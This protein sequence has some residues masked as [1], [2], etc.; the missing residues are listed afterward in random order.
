VAA[1]VA[2][3]Q[4]VRVR[5]TDGIG[6]ALRSQPN[7]HSRTPSGLAEGAV[8]EALESSNGYVRV[9]TRDGREGWIPDAY[10]DPNG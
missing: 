1:S 9:R 8:A 2:P 4:P 3:G 5:N 7:E 10:F 6:V